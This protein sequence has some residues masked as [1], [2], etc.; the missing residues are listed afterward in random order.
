M[1]FFYR[2]R[3]KDYDGNERTFVPC[4]LPREV[5]IVLESLECIS[6]KERPKR[7]TR[8]TTYNMVL[9]QHTLGK[10]MKDI[11]RDASLFEIYT[12]YWIRATALT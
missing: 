12:N 9:G 1:L 6:V 2:R 4:S 3:R 7:E 8:G 11:P 10:K 5:H